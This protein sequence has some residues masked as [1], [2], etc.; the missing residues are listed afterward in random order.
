MEYMAFIRIHPQRARYFLA[1][2]CLCFP[3]RQLGNDVVQASSILGL[4]GSAARSKL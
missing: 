2:H 1:L 3:I 4:D